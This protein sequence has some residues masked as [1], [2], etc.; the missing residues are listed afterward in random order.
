[1]VSDDVESQQ[2]LDDARADH[3]R[4]TAGQENAQARHAA[5]RSA[6]LQ[7]QK[8]V[9]MQEAAVGEARAR[10][11]V[12]EAI[13]DEA[14]AT[15]DKTEVRAPFDGIVVLKDAEVGE[16]VSPNSQ[17]GNSRGSVA[18][19]VDWSSLEVLVELQETSLAAAVVGEAASIY[20][21]AYPDVTYRGKVLRIWPTANRT[22]AT[23][24]V[25]VGFDAPDERLRP[26][27]GARVVFGTSKE[28]AAAAEQAEPSILISRKSVVR[29]DGADGVFVL[30]RDVVRFRAIELGDER[31]DRVRVD[32]GLT[33]GERIVAAPPTSLQDGDRVRIKE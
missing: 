20:L 25:R 28:P 9:A 33:S 13:R 7:A 26:E 5:A 14:K 17:G 32:N 21:D 23:V 10:I 16:V 1:M 22:K 31:G 30:E 3:A 15:L 12:L 4:A 24:E 8:R 19:M 29:I 11:P 6:V 27:M 18:T 2:W